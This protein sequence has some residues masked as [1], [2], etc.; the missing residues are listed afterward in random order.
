MILCLGESHKI[1]C[2]KRGDPETEE[3][4]AWVLMCNMCWSWRF[5]PKE[6]SPR[7]I[8]ELRCEE[9]A[10]KCLAGK[11]DYVFTKRT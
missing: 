6:Y 3:N 11:K 10:T 2:V 1:A 5:L 9:G 8:N 4:D 7:I